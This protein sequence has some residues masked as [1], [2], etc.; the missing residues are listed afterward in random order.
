MFQ[1]STPNVP[2]MFRPSALDIPRFSTKVEHWNIV[3]I[4]YRNG[5]FREVIEGSV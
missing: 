4:E 3:S 2:P 5:R 1:C